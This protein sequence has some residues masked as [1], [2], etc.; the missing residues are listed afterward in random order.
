MA[1]VRLVFVLALSLTAQASPLVP[2]PPVAA[3]ATCLRGDV[4]TLAGQIGERNCYHPEKLE[5]AA[6]WIEAQF[7]ATGLR[8]RR[9]PVEVPAGEPYRCGKMTVWNIEAESPGSALP[10]EIIVIGA[11]YDSK[12]AMKGWHDHAGPLAKLPGTPGADDNASGVAVTLALA[13]HFAQAPTR[14][15]LRFV[16]FVNEEP[17]FFQTGA[18]GSFVYARSLVQDKSRRVVGMFTPECLGC[19]SLQSNR[20]RVWLAGPLG[21]PAKPDYVAFMSNLSS[22]SFNLTAAAAFRRRCQVKLRPCVLPALGPKV[23]WSDDWA[24]WRQGVPAFAV[25]DTAFLRSD[26]YHELTDTPD[27]LDYGVMA[28]VTLGLQG[29]VAELGDR[30]AGEGGT[31]R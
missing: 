14:R 8:T 31:R 28:E 29:M 27:Y 9:L 16:A 5:R 1:L 15:S 26:R 11:H 24:F 20:K 19:Y 10:D 12:V 6:A 3:L 7:A 25:T 21:L 17:P 23:A 22:R 30:Q 13:R 18:M 2:E 4:E